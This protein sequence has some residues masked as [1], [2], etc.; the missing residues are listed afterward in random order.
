MDPSTNCWTILSSVSTF[1]AVLVALGISIIPPVYRR[2]R[3]TRTAEKRV[4]ETFSILNKYLEGYRTF[5]VSHM[6]FSNKQILR[7]YLPQETTTPIHINGNDLLGAIAKELEFLPRKKRSRIEELY[8]YGL[9]IFSG[10]PLEL[11]EWYRYEAEVCLVF[12]FDISQKRYFTFEIK[13]KNLEELIRQGYSHLKCI[14]CDKRYEQDDIINIIP[15]NEREKTVASVFG[16]KWC[17]ECKIPLHEQF[18]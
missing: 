16:K 7:S 6:S 11:I 18:K 3:L 2:F 13:G 14:I 17:P 5:H 1:F 8:L 12:D 10:M 9:E 4:K 15:D